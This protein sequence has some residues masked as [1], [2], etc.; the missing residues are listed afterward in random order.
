M[1]T[2]TTQK[3]KQEIL[4]E[5]IAHIKEH[6]P[7]R[8]DGLCCY[9]TPSGNMCAVGRCMSDPEAAEAERWGAIESHYD[10]EIEVERNNALPE[11]EEKLKPEY[12]GHEASFWDFLQGLHDYGFKG[13]TLIDD[14][15]SRLKFICS[16]FNLVDNYDKL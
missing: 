7:A 2:A 12:R 1:T 10:F 11:L 14:G 4:D 9:L 13:K 15:I 6:G 8:S 16:E 3:S 5:T